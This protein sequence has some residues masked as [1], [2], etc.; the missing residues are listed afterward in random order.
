MSQPL[1]ASILPLRSCA[2]ADPELFPEAGPGAVG[3]CLS[4]GGSRALTCAMGQLRGLRHL[5]LLEQVFAISSVSGGTWANAL[6]TYLPSD[7]TDDEFLG[8]VRLDPAQLSLS[9][10]GE[11]SA[12][13][14]G[15]VPTRLNPPALLEGLVTLKETYGYANSELW[16]GLVGELIL[17]DYQLWQPDA[18]GFDPRHVTWTNA[19]LRAPRGPLARNP[20]LAADDF[21]T[22][23]RPRP[24][25]VFNT[26][27]F[28][29]DG[30]DAD[31]IPFEANFMAGVR[32]SFEAGGG[33]Q[34]AVGGG[35]VETLAMASSFLKDADPGLVQTTTPAHAF[36]LSDIVSSSSAA[37]AQMLEEQYPDF[38]GL[39]PRYAYWPV[40][41]RASQGALNYRFADAGSL[42][43]LGVNALLARGVSR[44]IVFV[45][46]DQGVCRDPFSGE[47]IVSDDIPPLFGLQP[48]APGKGYVPYSAN[49]P[50][51]GPTRLYRH[52]QVFETAAFDALKQGLLAAR[53]AGGALLVRQQLQVMANSWFG[54]PALQQ[55]VEILWVYNDQV[56]SWWNQLP[57][58]SRDLLTLESV[59]DF[60]LYGT[61]TQLYLTPTMVNALAHLACWVVAS[62]STLGNPDGLSNADMFRQMFA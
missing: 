36:T 7:I 31:L 18:Q 51:E 17:K 39:V 47:V 43:N 44:L 27:M 2:P 59:D 30:V 49:D 42:E 34:G 41:A 33:M 32:A 8:G 53:R 55:P 61:F 28:S 10:L 1:L 52:S 23:K 4:G 12:N 46:T 24:V 56:S 48:Y 62:D 50:G 21:I 20:A 15:Q 54:V 9:V 40:G 25:P 57:W 35:L 58:E 19:Y 45:N 38:Q 6:F 14:L 16:Q 29:N 60:P 37:F 22:V 26:S 13:N 3:L 11:L 5:G